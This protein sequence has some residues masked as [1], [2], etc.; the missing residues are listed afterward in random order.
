MK[1]VQDLMD[2]V[3]AWSDSTFG[4]GDRALPIAYHL[5]KEVDELIEALKLADSMLKDESVN[6]EAYRR[7]RVAVKY[8]YADCLMLLLDSA[9]QDGL[10][11]E[12][13]RIFTERKLSINKF[14]EWGKPDENG[15]VE[16]IK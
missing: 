15:V 14:R 11:A 12:E 3:G 2:K 8:E 10:T 1:T 4:P 16:H 7:Q 6:P 9:R 13:L 5:K